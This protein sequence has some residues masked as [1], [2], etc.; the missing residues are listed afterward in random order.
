[1][2]R[3]NVMAVPAADRHARKAYISL[4]TAQPSKERLTAADAAMHKAA[5]SLFLLK[6]L[7]TGL[8]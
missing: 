5:C 8:P 2:F 6:V 3:N 1:M 7:E 4:P